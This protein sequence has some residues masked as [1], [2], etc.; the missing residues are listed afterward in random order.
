[1]V[2]FGGP[3]T[4]EELV[5]IH[6]PKVLAALTESVLELIKGER[7]DGGLSSKR[8]ERVVF[9]VVVAGVVGLLIVLQW[10]IYFS[11]GDHIGLSD[12]HVCHEEDEN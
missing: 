8:R 11:L 5:H 1:M 2:L 9:V 3:D 12:Y 4:I 10:Q 6:G 7:V